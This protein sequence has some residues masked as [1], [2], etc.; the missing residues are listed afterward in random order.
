MSRTAIIL[1]AGEARR[2]GFPKQRHAFEGVP[3]VRLAVSKARQAGFRPIVVLGAHREAVSEVL[4]ADTERVFNPD[5]A[6]GMGSS[7]LCGLQAA[8]PDDPALILLMVCDQPLVTSE[9]LR[10]LADACTTGEFDA[11]A[12]EYEGTVGTPA[13][14]APSSYRPLLG[15]NPRQGAGKLLR[16]GSLR[17]AAIAMPEAAFDV[18]TPD[19]LDR[20]EKK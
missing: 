11:A 1:A 13:C 20:L 12:A 16:S 5:W 3:L 10:S 18:D 19:D 14:F 8:M 7:V 17:V 9:G 4:D 6:S 15:L 2:M